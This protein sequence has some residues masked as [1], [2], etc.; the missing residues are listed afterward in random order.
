MPVKKK[1]KRKS[2][3]KKRTC[4]IC[5]EKK[6]QNEMIRTVC[7]DTGYICYE[8][9]RDLHPEYDIDEW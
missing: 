5:G 9:D 1:R 2:P 6:P 7:S 3:P 8:C 4:G